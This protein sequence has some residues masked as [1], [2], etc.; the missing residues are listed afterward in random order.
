[1]LVL[2]KAIAWRVLLAIPVIAVVTFG[3]AALTDLMPGSPAIAILGDN[4]TPE[5]IAALNARYGYDRPVLERYFDW[6]GG[7]LRGDLGTTLFGNMPIGEVLMRRLGVTLQLAALGIIGALLFAV[8]FALLA[9][10]RPGGFLDRAL[11][12]V[13]SAIIAVP[14]FVMVVLLSL[15]FVVL[16]GAFPATGWVGFER[17]PLMNL[18]FAALP[19]LTL[20]INESAYFYRV[21]L[22]DLR[23]TLREDFILVARTKGIPRNYILWRHTLRPSLSSLVTVLGLTVGR[24]L[25]GAAIVEF[26]FGVP[27][28]GAE[29]INAVSIKDMAMVQAIVMLCVI[30]YVL[31]FIVVDIAYAVIDPRVSVR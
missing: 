13:T 27:G 30:V 14:T 17:D 5:S 25:G 4:A 20:A 12:T 1:M 9:S 18:R 31:A 23:G 19:A 26:F 8:P 22:A 15:V 11:D 10:S 21:L 6:L 3:A 24:L 7:L 28:L 16:L 2:T 29:A